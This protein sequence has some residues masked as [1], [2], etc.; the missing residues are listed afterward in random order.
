MR[1]WGIAFLLVGFVA[2]GVC[3]KG[4]AAEPLDSAITVI[5]NRHAGADMVRSFFHPGPDG[6]I[7]AQAADDAIKRLYASG[8][9]SNVKVSRAGDRILVVVVENPTI[10]RLAL[11][12]NR[13]VK[14]EDLKKDLQSKSGGP[15]SR[16]TI[17]N[18]VVR[19]LEVY[20][21]YGYFDTQ[22]APKTIE[23]KPGSN[24]TTV[25]L[26]FEIKEGEKLAVRRVMFAGNQR[27]LRN[28]ARRRGQDRHDQ[29]RELSA[30]QRYLRRRQDRER[31]R[32][33]AP[34]LSRSRLCR[35]AGVV[36]RRAMTRRP[37]ASP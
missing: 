19:M 27:L 35:R 13:K 23:P 26:V 15:L 4:A 1:C 16:A 8:L 30:Q 28:Q 17:Q 6:K 11:E 9:F 21:R 31:P 34:I 37:K 5:G 7:D 24:N 14:D 29:C 3:A 10:G 22:I 12:G 25:D 20:K 2:L 18:D 32:P 33:V 36:G